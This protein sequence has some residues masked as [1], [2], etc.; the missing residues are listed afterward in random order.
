MSTLPITRLA[1]YKHGVA[2]FRPRGSIE[3]EEV[4]QSFRVRKVCLPLAVSQPISILYERCMP[5]T[6][7]RPEM[8]WEGCLVSS[9][10]SH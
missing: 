1:H 4:S 9:E 5:F 8:Q 2:L 6:R 10:G 7:E 3:A